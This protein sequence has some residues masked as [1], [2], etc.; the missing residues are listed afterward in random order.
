M[1][2]KSSTSNQALLN[3][4]NFLKAALG[5]GVAGMAMTSAPR[6]ARAVSAQRNHFIAIPTF[7]GW[8]TYLGHQA[9]LQSHLGGMQIDDYNNLRTGSSLTRRFLESDLSSVNDPIGGP[10]YMGPLWADA[11]LGSIYS[12]MAIW[13]GLGVEGGHGISNTLLHHGTLSSYAPCYT[14]LIAQD[15]SLDYLRPLHYVQVS[16]DQD[17]LHMLSG[18][19]P[20][21]PMVPTQIPDAATWAALT[22]LPSAAGNYRRNFVNTAVRNLASTA[23][24][25]PLSP[26]GA[27]SFAN[28]LAAYNGADTIRGTG[29]ASSPAFQAIVASYMNAITAGL[30]A[31]K[32]AGRYPT[33]SAGN[34]NANQYA[35]MAFGFALAEFLVAKDLSAVVATPGMTGDNHEFDDNH[36]LNMCA[37]YC[38]FRQLVQNL[39][40]TPDPSRPGQSLLDCTT[41]AM[42]SDFDRTYDCSWLSASNVARPG[43][44]HGASASVVMA[45]ARINTG[46]VFGDV[47]TGA[48][49]VYTSFN[50]VPF[51]NPLPVDPAKGIPATNGILYSERA[52]LPTMLAIFG[53]PVPSQQL[54][55]QVALSAIV[56]GC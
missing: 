43:T 42:E 5:A 26:A 45:G 35:Q 16:P 46:R 15:L 20:T 34:V 17:S 10:R 51:A 36:Y 4:R 23:L 30:S 25:S 28:F 3:R 48:T 49:G 29:Y 33:V 44:A 54:T 22:S 39:G 38:C 50:S 19:L 47:Q 52:L 13:R 8:D 21:A 53:I 9:M 12:R 32:A 11:Q 41:I 37:T 24:S 6:I 40:A 27:T 55:D 1:K 2:R 7:G 14:A 56:R 18:L 31:A